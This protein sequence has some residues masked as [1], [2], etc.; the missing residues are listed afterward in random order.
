MKR[1]P[2]VLVIPRSVTTFR[3]FQSDGMFGTYLPVMVFK[4]RD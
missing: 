4:V 2:S 1:L 3:V